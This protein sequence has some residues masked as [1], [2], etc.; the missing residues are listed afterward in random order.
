[1]SSRP[2][3]A[4]GE[5]EKLKLLAE[6]LELSGPMQNAARHAHYLE[7]LETEALKERVDRLRDERR[8]EVETT[9]PRPSPPKAERE[10]APRRYKEFMQLT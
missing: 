4:T 10:T 6:I 2:P 5:G 7:G 3:T 8:E 9:S 1:M